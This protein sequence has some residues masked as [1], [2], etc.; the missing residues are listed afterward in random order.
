MRTINLT[1]DEKNKID[2]TVISNEAQN[3]DNLLNIEENTYL[4]ESLSKAHERVE[5]SYSSYLKRKMV[6]EKKEEEEIKYIQQKNPT[7]GLKPVNRLPEDDPFKPTEEDKNIPSVE[8]RRPNVD[9]YANPF[10]YKGGVPGFLPNSPTSLPKNQI[11]SYY[12]GALSSTKNYTEKKLKGWNWGAFYFG[13]IWGLFNTR[14]YIGIL[15]FFIEGIIR[16]AAVC[17]G[18]FV[19]GPSIPLPFLVIGAHLIYRFCLG[20][21]GNKIS[22]RLRYW[23]DVDNLMLAQDQWRFVT[24]ILYLIFSIVYIAG[25]LV[26]W[27]FGFFFY[28]PGLFFLVLSIISLFFH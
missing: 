1:P 12:A 25:G 5:Q 26:I 17:L 16:T 19:I 14:W 27:K 15:M 23:G 4:Q 11:S 24:S 3:N 20:I 21:Y 13:W 7:E 28:I 10:T 2:N 9:T 18:I 22:W 6:E 8:Q